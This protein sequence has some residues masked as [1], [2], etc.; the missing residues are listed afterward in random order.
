MKNEPLTSTATLR[1]VSFPVGNLILSVAIDSVYRVLSQIP[2]YGSGERGVGIAHLEDYELTVFD[3]EYYLFT[4]KQEEP[5]PASTGNHI[6]VVQ[7]A[8]EVIGLLVKEAP[9]LRNLPRDRVRALPSSYRQT[10]T[11][12]FCSHVAVLEQEQPTITV[13]LL[14]VEQLFPKNN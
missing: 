12:S 11:L 13:F 2:V 1:V 4:R 8:T 14:D 10:D 6:I 5:Q 7:S 9:T 3:L